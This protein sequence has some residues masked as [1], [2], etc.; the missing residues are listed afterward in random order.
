VENWNL[1]ANGRFWPDSA[2]VSSNGAFRPF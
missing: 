2:G 1:Q